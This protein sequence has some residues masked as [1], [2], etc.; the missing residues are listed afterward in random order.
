MDFNTSL[1]K[2]MRTGEVIL[3]QNRVKEAVGAG[4]AKLVILARNCP[5]PFRKD[6]EGNRELKVY[7]YE[8]TNMEL[9]KACGK[10]FGVSAL[11][12]TNPG[13]SDILSLVG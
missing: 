1:R 2:A 13:E 10:A 4:K 3:G 9:G 8:G 7:V 5:A 6:I 12:V 11:A